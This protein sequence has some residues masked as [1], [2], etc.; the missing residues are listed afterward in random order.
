MKIQKNVRWSLQ[1]VAP[2][3]IM[4]CIKYHISTVPSVQYFFMM[5]TILVTD[6]F[7]HLC[8]FFFFFFNIYFE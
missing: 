5:Q 6:P 2:A 7:L 1:S 8:L 3:T 4:Q